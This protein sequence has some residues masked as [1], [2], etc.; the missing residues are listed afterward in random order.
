MLE[1]GVVWVKRL[2]KT[3][4]RAAWVTAL[5]A[6]TAVSV[7]AAALFGFSMV[8][9]QAE[10]V[11]LRQSIAERPAQSE[12]PDDFQDSPDSAPEEAPPPPE[13]PSYQELYPELYAP[14]AD[15]SSVDASNVAYLTF[16]D[17]PSART[18]EI[19]RILEQYG[20]KAT[21]FVV[22]AETEEAK[23]WMRDI[24]SAGHTLGI[25]SY[26]HDYQKIYASVEAY[27]EDFSQ[28]Y[29]LIVE[30]TG[31][32]PQ[33]FRFPGG[34][35]NAYNTATYHEIISEMLRRGFVYYDWNRMNGDAVKGV[36]PVETLV[37]NALSKPENMRRAIVL[38][39]DSSRFTNTVAALPAIIE[40]YQSL[41]YTLDALTPE[42][43]PIVYAYP[44]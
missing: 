19:L 4:P 36:V 12:P 38:M 9:A 31:S 40:G 8:R 35:I 13:S 42:V 39:H 6:L 27:L 15:Y 3:E 33:I 32:A 25:H 1:M 26:S 30:A 22:G 7:L 23:Q 43:R 14:E 5:A 29:H 2:A 17:G 44:R 41:G 37:R 28:I 10:L 21:F 11:Q 20:V 16:D 18:P 24:V 34:S